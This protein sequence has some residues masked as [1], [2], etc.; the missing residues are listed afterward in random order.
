[1]TKIDL[2][3]IGAV[4]SPGPGHDFIDVAIQLEDLGYGTIWVTGGPLDNLGQ[5]ADVVRATK[6]VRVASGVISVDRFG[7]DEVAGLYAELAAT[8]PAASLS[9]SGAPTDRNHWRP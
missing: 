5:I 7:A 8:H 4:V 1:M 9:G 6:S 2:G 3:H